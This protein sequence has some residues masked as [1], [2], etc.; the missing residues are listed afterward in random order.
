MTPEQRRIAEPLALSFLGIPY[1]WGGN[2]PNEGLDCS[3]L[4][5]EI[6]QSLDVLPHGY[7][8]T[9]QGLYRRFG[10]DRAI[11]PTEVGFGDLVFYGATESTITHMG[12]CLSN[13]I[14]LEAGGGTRSMSSRDAGVKGNGRVRIRPIDNRRDLVGFRRPEY[15]F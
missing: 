11:V 14:M 13:T 6:L 1:V 7:D 12:F 8:S 2:N 10:V 3:G 4:V 15:L 9:A 5:I